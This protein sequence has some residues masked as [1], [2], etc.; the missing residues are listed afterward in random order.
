MENN[1]QPP[2]TL[3]AEMPA[4]AFSLSPELS[5][6]G[7]KFPELPEDFKIQPLMNK[8]LIVKALP[9]EKRGSILVAED[10]RLKDMTLCQIGKILAVGP[11]WY[12]HGTLAD[13]PRDQIPKVGDIVYFSPYE[14]IARLG[15]KDQEGLFIHLTEESVV[16]IIGDEKSA[17]K[18]KFYA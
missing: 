10:T 7:T 9:E 1:W 5:A 17:L 6:F 18:L 3:G 12:A 2:S 4:R 8:A 15:M 13:I 14:G 16:S 11:L